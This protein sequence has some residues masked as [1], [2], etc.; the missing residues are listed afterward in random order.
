MFKKLKRKTLEA[1]LLLRK[2]GLVLFTWGNASQLDPERRHMAIKP[3]G[4]EYDDLTPEK[5]CVLNLSDGA[6]VEGELSPST[7]AQTHL[8]LYRHFTGVYGIVHTHS[9]HAT[10]FAQAGRAIPCYGT[11][12]ADYFYGEIPCARELW[13]EEINNNYELSTGRVII[14]KFQELSADPLTIPGALVCGHGPFTWGKTAADA[15]ANAAYLEETARLAYITLQIEHNVRN[16]RPTAAPRVAALSGPAPQ[17]V[18]HSGMKPVS[19]VLLDKHYLRKHGS[20]AYY[21]QK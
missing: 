6:V 8:E 18:A 12:H 1:N 17:A 14:K 20:G 19:Q 9:T 2:Y 5:I 11:T 21:G 13:P 4:V 3:S 7:D 15:A 10:A 16:T